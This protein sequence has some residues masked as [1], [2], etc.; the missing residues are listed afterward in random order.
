MLLDTKKVTEIC[1][2]LRIDIKQFYFLYLISTKNYNTMRYYVNNI[3][4]FS[5]TFIS[6]LEN[7][8][9]LLDTKIYVKDSDF[10]KETGTKI[11]SMDTL[12][13]TPDFD[14]KLL[15]YGVDVEVADCYEDILDVYPYEITGTNGI[16]YPARTGTYE[17]N[18]ALYTKYIS[19][20]ASEHDKIIKAIKFGKENDLI[21][22]GIEKF[23]ENKYWGLLIEAMEGNHRQ[24][25]EGE[26]LYGNNEF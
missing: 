24:T 1:V 11:I 23:I 20:H 9:L 3:D 19:K 10:N 14:T 2:K 7:K 16:R 21:K 22:W 25:G 17:K 4:G 6:S 26:S 13:T 8:G 12:Y 5:E 18:S 15:E